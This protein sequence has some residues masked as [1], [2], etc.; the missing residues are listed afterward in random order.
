MIFVSIKTPPQF[1]KDSRAYKWFI[2]RLFATLCIGILVAMLLM[3]TA[4][5]VEWSN[6]WSCEHRCYIFACILM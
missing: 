1:M 4:L 2:P 6:A 3:I 5:I